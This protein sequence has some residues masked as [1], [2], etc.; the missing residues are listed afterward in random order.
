MKGCAVMIRSES[1]EYTF[2]PVLGPVCY[3]EMIY[4]VF[5][6]FFCFYAV[7][8]AENYLLISILLV[9]QRKFLLAKEMVLLDTFHMKYII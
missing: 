4:K 5:L 7:M 8:K 3:N 1:S 9:A 2:T 6:F